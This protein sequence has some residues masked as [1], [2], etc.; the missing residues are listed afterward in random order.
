MEL[1]YYESYTVKNLATGKVVAE[2]TAKQ[3]RSFTTSVAFGNVDVFE[4]TAN[5]TRNLPE[6]ETPDKG[7]EDIAD[8]EDDIYD[9]VDEDDE[10]DEEEDEESKKVVIKHRRK[11]KNNNKNFPLGWVIGGSVAAALLIAGAI[12]WIILYKKRKKNQTPAEQ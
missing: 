10:P 6:T 4:V 5:G 12:I 11:K 9:G 3:I 2:G 1:D 8:T 7:D